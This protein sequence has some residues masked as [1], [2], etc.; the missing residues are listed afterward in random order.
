[1]TSS[2]RASSASIS[3]L[4]IKATPNPGAAAIAS[5]ENNS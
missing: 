2:P 1:M 5:I 3:M 4:G